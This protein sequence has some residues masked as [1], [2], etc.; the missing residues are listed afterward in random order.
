MT[1]EQAIALAQTKWWEGLSAHDVVMFQ[2]FESLLCMDFCTYHAALE[3]ALCRTVWTHEIAFP[4]RLQRE[5][6]GDRCPPTFEEIVSLIP[7][8]KR[9]VLL[10]EQS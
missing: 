9:I 7:A 4:A 1:K 2:L 10:R 3:E 8:D 6:L 5:F